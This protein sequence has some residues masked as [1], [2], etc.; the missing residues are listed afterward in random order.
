MAP[1]D[2]LLSDRVDLDA[3]VDAVNSQPTVDVPRCIGRMGRRLVLVVGYPDGSQRHVGLDFSGCGSIKIGD[4]TRR[5]PAAPYTAFVRLL[6]EQ[7][8]VEEPPAQVP[9]PACLPPYADSDVAEPDEMVAA[10]LCVTYAD[11]GR[12]TSVRVPED[13]LA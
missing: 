9:T 5:D 2:I 11:S 3:L 10:R 7:R 13:D 6:R 1:A 8:A 4:V 12:T